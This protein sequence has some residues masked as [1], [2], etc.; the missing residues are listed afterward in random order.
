AEQRAILARPLPA[1][2]QQTITDA[3]E[4]A[5]AVAR[6]RQQ[7]YAI[8]RGER[9]PGAVGIAA[10]ILGPGANC[11]GSIGITLPEQRFP[12]KNEGRTAGQETPP[13]GP[14]PQTLPR[15]PPLIVPPAVP[16]GMRVDCTPLP[17]SFKP[18]QS[19]H[20]TDYMALRIACC[21]RAATGRDS[22]CR[23]ASA[24]R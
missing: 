15:P 17:P 1:I 5:R 20:T 22:S 21:R 2:T 16:Y 14:H 9:T 10:P 4:L 6:I 3:S 24:T 8:T 18:V 23:A 7:G 12:P 19:S 11:I 13:R